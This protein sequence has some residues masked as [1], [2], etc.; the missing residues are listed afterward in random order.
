MK[1]RLLKMLVATAFTLGVSFLGYADG[2]DLVKANVPQIYGKA[3]SAF[4]G[5]SDKTII[6]VQD[7]H[8]NAESQENIQAIVKSL[9]EQGKIDAISD[10]GR[11]G[12]NDYS[13]FEGINEEDTQLY[14]D[15]LTK[16]GL[17]HAASRYHVLENKNVPV[18]GCETKALYNENKKA[19]IDSNTDKKASTAAAATI[20]ASMEALKLKLFDEDTRIVLQAMDDFQNDK[21]TLT[22]FSKVLKSASEKAAVNWQSYANFSKV[23]ES[24]TLEDAIDFA[25]IDR[26]RLDMVDE[27]EGTVEKKS[28]D[29]IVNNSLN[30]RLGRMSAADYYAFLLLKAGEAKIDM[31]KYDNVAKYAK[32][33]KVYAEINDD[34]LFAETS[35]LEAEIKAKMFKN[36]SQVNFD[37]HLK[38]LDVLNRMINLQ[39]TRADLAYYNENKPK[40]AEMIAFLKDQSKSLGLGIQVDEALSK[41]DESLSS[42]VKFY[43]I[44]LKRDEAMIENTLA[45]M[46]ER[47]FKTVVLVA[48]GFHTEGIMKSLKAKGISHNV[49]T[50][51]ITNPDAPNYWLQN[52]LGEKTEGVKLLEG[53]ANSPKITTLQ[54]DTDDASNK[55]KATIQMTVE[56]IKATTDQEI[57]RVASNENVEIKVAGNKHEIFIDGKTVGLAAEATGAVAAEFKNSGLVLMLATND[58]KAE[59]KALDGILLNGKQALRVGNVVYVTANQLKNMEA[60]VLAKNLILDTEKAEY[61]QTKDMKN[62]ADINKKILEINKARSNEQ[63]VIDQF[64]GKNLNAL[65]EVFGEL[66]DMLP[67]ILDQQ[68]VNEAIKQNPITGTLETKDTA[69]ALQTFQ[70]I[71]NAANRMMLLAAQKIM[72]KMQADSGVQSRKGLVNLILRE[73]GTPWETFIDEKGN[74][75]LTGASILKSYLQSDDGLGG[76]MAIV[77]DKLAENLKSI[78]KVYLSFNPGKEMGIYEDGVINVYSLDAK[79]ELVASETQVD[80]KNLYQSDIKVLITKS[81][82]KDAVK[83]FGANKNVRII[84]ST[85]KDQKTYDKLGVKTMSADMAAADYAVHDVAFATIENQD[86]AKENQVTALS[87]R[88]QKHTKVF[89][90]GDQKDQAANAMKA[91][92]S[93]LSEGAFPK[94]TKFMVSLM[95]ACKSAGLFA[96]AA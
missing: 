69:D 5:N 43:E 89:D 62:D 84:A 74:I 19:F 35:R 44:A 18:V 8:G 6:Y 55:P 40:A 82:V 33:V 64:I 63:Q 58:L 24:V 26:E 95:E 75:S 1:S 49:I 68:L 11:S 93:I 52:M 32:L 56:A 31:T 85:Q 73:D 15:F 22:A 92:E 14:M 27:L 66:T 21:I 29:E 38:G 41:I 86:Q 54:S 83:D 53:A 3:K 51:R 61:N 87:D 70:D 67:L 78:L 17:T 59:S 94:V 71:E 46:D 7:A 42:N 39:M 20:K 25:K 81:N 4:T 96:I 34:A 2:K 88:L 30:Y 9:A 57:A 60:S 91:A 48:G 80:V 77:D 45:M 16:W 13:G 47:G 10:E 23:I 50:P 36:E 37:K 28:A 76:T 65:A 72:E 90:L 79:G 12:E